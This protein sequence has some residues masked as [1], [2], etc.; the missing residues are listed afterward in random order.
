LIRCR[1]IDDANH[2]QLQRKEDERMSD[3]APVAPLSL[4]AACVRSPHCPLLPDMFK[5]RLCPDCDHRKSLEHWHGKQCRDCYNQQH[6]PHPAAAVAAAAPPSSPSP[7]AT[8]FTRDEHS[9]GHLS[10]EQRIAIRI[11]HKEGRDEAYIAARIPCD[12]RSVRHWLAQEDTYDS[13]RSGRKRKT[14]A[15]QDADVLAE[16]QETKFTTPRRI[17]RKLQLNVSVATIDR[18]LIDA[19]LP[20]RVARHVF[21]LTDDHKRQRLSF[22]NGYSRWTEDDWCRV[23][24]A[25]M[26]TF[27]GL[28]R[29][30]QVWVRRPVGEASNP[31]YSV[32]HK[33][34]PVSVPAWGCFSAAGPGYMAMFEGS[35]EAAGL[36]DIFRDYLLP[37]V[38]EQFGEGADWWLLHDNDPGRHKSHVLKVFMHNNYIRPLE[39]PPYSPDLNPIE[40]L[41]ADMDKRMD[42]ID[43]DT[44]E[45]LEKVVADTWAATSKEYCEQ[46]ARSMPVRIQQVIDRNGA[47]TD[48]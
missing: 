20:G 17:R 3:D 30:G 44:K 15:K 2:S 27:R 46:L 32:A 39:F 10:Q 33:P 29:G 7:P 31:Q 18:R 13:P 34:H 48:Y 45:E 4:A 37:T 1:S 8:L 16:A 26:K 14:T 28:G 9:H 19:G 36:R 38:K 23:L 11:L 12:V 25:D 5:Q 43:A 6:P 40:N 42:L 35:M 47:Y 24:F 41:W 22:A 21:Q